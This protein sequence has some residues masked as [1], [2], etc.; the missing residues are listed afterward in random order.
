[1]ERYE[2]KV[3]DKVE[4]LFNGGEGPSTCYSPGDI[5]IIVEGGRS[6]SLRVKDETKNVLQ[7]VYACQI[8][9]FEEAPNEKDVNGGYK[10]GDYIL[11]KFVSWN[12][13]SR[14]A[15]I[16]GFSAAQQNNRKIYGYYAFIDGAGGFENNYFGCISNEN[17]TTEPLDRN[18]IE[19]LEYCINNKKFIPAEQI[20][21]IKDNSN[22]SYKS[23]FPSIGW[24]KDADK[25]LGHYLAK[26]FDQEYVN[27][28]ASGYAWNLNSYWPIETASGKPVVLFDSLHKTIIH[29][30]FSKDV[31]K[32]AEHSTGTSIEENKSFKFKKDDVVKICKTRFGEPGKHQF[33]LNTVAVINK[34]NVV[35]MLPYHCVFGGESWW[36]AE[37][38]LEKCNDSSL[39][40]SNIKIGDIVL[41]T[42]IKKSFTSHNF[43]EGETVEC[44]DLGV[45]QNLFV[46]R[47]RPTQKWWLFPREYVL[48]SNP[49]NNSGGIQKEFYDSPFPDKPMLTGTGGCIRQG[50]GRPDNFIFGDELG[51]RPGYRVGH[52]PFNDI[53][54]SVFI[55]ESSPPAENTFTKLQR[56]LNLPVNSDKTEIKDR[57]VKCVKVTPKIKEIEKGLIVPLE[58]IKNRTIKYFIKKS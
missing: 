44:T 40:P 6:D 21:N 43:Y 38:D 48:L 9:L 51:Q 18:Q 1:M 8:K 45:T 34:I 32:I 30:A 3:G 22:T 50:G 54:S 52:D 42:Q 36:V 2:Y 57:I 12:I 11:I 33:K 39:I 31:E 56:W 15:K 17:I 49:V 58:P 20:P 37:E 41:V 16:K 13:Q 47:E 26:R 27:P 24:C 29:E 35:G 19:W 10:I 23:E 55:K 25:S 28:G 53:G 7:T 14:M 46:S 5:L 4:L